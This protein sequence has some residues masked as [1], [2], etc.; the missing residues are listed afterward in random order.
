MINF[1]SNFTVN[2]RVQGG[3]D[4]IMKVI[5]YSIQNMK[6][7]SKSKLPVI[8]LFTATLMLLTAPFSINE[9]FANHLSE[10][11]KW[12]LVYISSQPACSNYH[13]QMTNTFNDISLKYMDLYQ[14]EHSSYDPLCI[15]EK[16]YYSDYQSPNDLDLIILVYDR[17]LGEKELHENKMG[18]LYT[19]SGLDR[20]Q[21]HAVIICDCANFYFSTPPWILT[22]ELSHFILY[23]KNFEMSVIEDAIH[24]NDLKY[25]QCLQDYT[26]DCKSSSLKL[27]AGHSL[28]SYS[29]MPVY[30]PAV[31]V[32]NANEEKRATNLGPVVSDLSKII[33]KWWAVGKITDGDYANAIGYVVDSNILSSHEDLRIIMA[34]DPIDP[35]PTWV[36]KFKEL[37]TQNSEKPLLVEN[38]L[39]KMLDRIPSNLISDE[40]KFFSE[41]NK[42]GLPEWF[43]ET[44][45]WWSQDKITDKEFKKNVE[46]LVT[47]GVVNSHTNEVFDYLVT[48][49][50][51]QTESVPVVPEVDEQDSIVNL[52]TNQQKVDPEKIT[53][54]EEFEV[55]KE[56][57]DALSVSK[58]LSNEDHAS[59]IKYVKRA[60]TNFDADNTINSC[61]ILDNFIFKVK[62]ILKN[63]NIPQIDSESLISSAEKIKMDLC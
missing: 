12:Q 34:D 50:K 60:T 22:H 46:F 48:D 31:G 5:P 15:P 13:F 54:S 17:N 11:L 51:L 35:T 21:N 57:V 43:K 44:A 30:E 28:Y 61:Q 9:A 27:D 3:K 62:L 39:D 49:S 25:D 18:G 26:S 58:V 59:L 52:E 8:V 42:L 7:T 4:Y 29:V 23:Y 45:A 41:E 24:V 2:K 55:L 6:I 32:T 47:A 40:E 10:E 63:D 20:T 37:A 53:I 19:H 36:D 33:T 14:I 1:I 56:N 16:K 38:P